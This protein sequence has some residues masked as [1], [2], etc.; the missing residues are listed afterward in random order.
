MTTLTNEA[1]ARA[2]ALHT[3]NRLPEAEPFY[4]EALELDPDNPQALEGLGVLVFQL[5]RAAEAAELFARGVEREPGTALLH[6]NLGEALRVLKRLDEAARELNKAVRLDPTLF[7]TW[8]SLGLLAHDRG[9][10]DEA[11]RACREAL[12][13]RPRFAA[14]YINLGNTFFARR[15][16][17]EAIEA[18]RT[19]L[20]VEPDNFIALTNLG[21]V[22]CELGR[23]DVLGEA[24]AVCRRAALLAPHLPQVHNNLGTA[25]RQQGR[26]DEALACYQSA[27]K[28]NPRE[29][30][31][32][33]LIGQV[34]KQSGKHEEAAQFLKGE[35]ELQPGNPQPHADYAALCVLRGEH[36]EA[37][38]HYGQALECDA[39]FA[40]AHHGL[41]VSLLEQGE[42]DR[43][44]AYFRE[45]LRQN[46]TLAI[47]WAALA[48]LQAERGDLE[49]S[50]ESA[51]SALTANP[52]L[53]E[54]YWRLA[55]NLK[56]KVPD[57]EF[58]AM[59]ARLESKYLAAP[60]RAMLLF[61]L[62]AVYDG[63]GQFARAAE[64]LE[65][66]NTIQAAVKKAQGMAYD[67]AS[68]S[69][70]L[71]GMITTFTPEFLAARR[72]W[73][74]P[75]LRPVFVVGLPRS[76]TSLVEQILA[77]HPRVYGA[78][79][80]NDLHRVLGALPELLHRPGLNV[81]QAL[82]ALTPEAAKSASKMYLT[83]LDALAPA[84]AARVVDKMPDNFRLIGLIAMLWP[85]G[86]VVV[87][88]RDLRDIA[89]SCWQVGFERNTW[90]NDW[91]F[92][93][94]RLAD[95]QRM[96]RHWR[97]TRPLE[98]LDVSY[99]HL[100]NNLETD[101]RRMIDFLGLE[102]DPACL[103]FHSTRR[104]VRTAS[105][106]Q[107]RTPIYTHSVGR[108]RNYEASIQPLLRAC[109]QLGVEVKDPN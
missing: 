46:P 58:Q 45:A 7:Q 91:Q 105:L 65:Q 109:E 10:Y 56:G 26:L 9:Q 52:D 17:A 106:V 89:V 33:G 32:R 37:A 51:R 18:F 4:R 59:H 75:D 68:H 15:R 83:A 67:A 81:I 61:A 19:A 103:D 94:H 31:T 96:M 36:D 23:L 30:T 40:D 54:A 55:I 29:K 102:W 12:R 38:R 107:V 42:L 101:A 88:S 43:A 50:C 87:C 14:G 104:V 3:R 90:T 84:S 13:L 28:L 63:R 72:G 80:L 57:A 100:V 21:Q 99:E 82:H 39:G 44:E 47:S 16:R 48:R 25:L 49:Q 69:R 108:W 86:R 64:C 34:L 27:L 71:A 60:S 73:G 95:Y 97:H 41:G 8:N 66:A 5:G 70:M 98:W 1:L 78:G 35:M 22:L 24:E 79:E 6:A 20:R 92:M 85:F 76:G 62:A 74:N 53:I 11:E 93:A 77:S 2:L